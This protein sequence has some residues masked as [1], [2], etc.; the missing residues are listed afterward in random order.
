MQSIINTVPSKDQMIHSST[1]SF[2]GSETAPLRILI[3][4]NS[5][6]RHGPKAEI[7]WNCDWGM[8]ASAP[9][10]DYVHR[11]YAKLTE[12]GC[13]AYLRVRQASEWERNLTS[14]DALDAFA[15][16]QAFEAD[17]VIFRLGENVKKEDVSSFG[18]AIRA[19]LSHVASKA[20]RVILTTCFWKSPDKDLAIREVAQE[21]DAV[22]VEIT[23]REDDMMA[24]GLFD[25]R[26]VAIH[27]GD[28]GMEMIAD[29]IFAALK[30]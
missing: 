26:G 4:G 16:D 25:H 17:V 13:E 9:E 28:A 14:P 1:V 27:P 21:R 12:S 30:K 19:L 6:T 3:L 29:R 5:I 22:L 23:C 8:A 2:L 7:G 20:S 24:L 10:K 15:E 11:L 18:P